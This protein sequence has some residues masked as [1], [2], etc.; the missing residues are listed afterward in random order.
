MTAV[1]FFEKIESTRTH[2]RTKSR[3]VPLNCFTPGGR[4]GRECEHPVSSEMVTSSSA[5]SEARSGSVGAGN[6]PRL[7][8]A[9]KGKFHPDGVETI[10]KIAFRRYARTYRR[11]SQRGLLAF[12]SG[13]PRDATRKN[14]VARYPVGIRNIGSRLERFAFTGS[15]RI[16][17]LVCNVDAGR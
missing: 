2:R 16:P 8:K 10:R 9:H 7:Y 3:L 17:R 11:V 12:V 5:D 1:R 4:S 6:A 13:M 15:L 14:E